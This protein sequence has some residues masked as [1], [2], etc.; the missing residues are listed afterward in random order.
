LDSETGNGSYSNAG[1]CSPIYISGSGREAKE[2]TLAGAAL[3]AFKKAGFSGLN[4]E[5]AEGDALVFHT[6]GIIEARNKF[7]QELG[8]SQFAQLARKCWD[9]DPE[10]IYQGLYQ[11]YLRH[12]GGQAPE[13]DLTMVVVVF[14]GA[15]REIKIA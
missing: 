1:A 13:D 2:L 4:L 8:Y 5:F 11:A 10:K 9:P 14:K 12:I 6:D 15:R 3:G 7:G